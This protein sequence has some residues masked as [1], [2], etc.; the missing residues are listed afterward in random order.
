[1]GA[2]I[3]LRP[4]FDAG[5][6]RALAKQSCDGAQGRRLLA[7]A[8][9]YDGSRRSE[10]ARMAGVGLQIVRDWVLRFNAEGP[11]GLRNRKG[12]R[13]PRKVTDAHRTF[14]VELVAAD[15]DP[16]V[17]GVVRWRRCDL[18][19]C[20]E[21]QFGVTLHESTIGR[22]L[23]EMGYAKL[24]ARPCHYAQDKQKVDSFKK[25]CDQLTEVRAQLE[26][27]IE[28]EIWWQDE[29]RIGQK[30]KLTRR[31]AKRGTR[32]SAPQDQR[33]SWAYIFGA[34][35]P[36]KAKAAG[37]V[38]PYANTEAMELHLVE[39]SRI[40]A[41]GAHAVLLLDQ[42]GWHTTGKLNCPDNIT[43]LPLPPRAPEL[44][45]M[46]NVWQYMRD[47]WLSNLVFETYDDIVDTCCDAWN[48]FANQPHR[49]RSIGQ[50]DWANGF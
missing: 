32:P 4:D 30:N 12:C 10:A 28:I 20:V 9:I 48:R 44:N 39:I 35:C 15:P 19:R 36:G 50:R 24:S 25:F 45:S 21:D 23:R 42:A 16:T 31:W 27:G 17:H 18:A 46:E 1:M 29:A 5:Q 34:I 6:L 14:L 37:L 3:A 22:V 7:L 40:V 41:K 43:L 38:M 49:I 47:N 8:M 26:A 2:A 11:D 13:P 33:T